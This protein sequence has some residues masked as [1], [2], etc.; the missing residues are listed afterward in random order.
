ML[1]PKEAREIPLEERKK[2]YRFIADYDNRHEISD[3]LVGMR[4]AGLL[5][6][7]EYYSTCVYDTT[8]SKTNV[9]V[10]IKDEKVAM[11]FRLMGF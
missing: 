2:W 6:S 1:A 3:W 8:T 9:A 5:V 11:Y 4:R 7:S 10:M